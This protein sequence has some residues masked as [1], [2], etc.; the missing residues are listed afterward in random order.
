MNGEVYLQFVFKWKHKIIFRENY[1]CSI[2]AAPQLRRFDIWS[3]IICRHHEMNNSDFSKYKI[4]T[5]KSKTKLRKIKVQIINH[6]SQGSEHGFHVEW[7]C[8]T[9]VGLQ[10]ERSN[11]FDLSLNPTEPFNFHTGWNTAPG[12]DVLSSCSFSSCD[13]DWPRQQ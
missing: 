8:T 9:E 1:F 12:T 2:R 11:R 7:L 5:L 6:T 13:Q 4:K 3:K 10:V